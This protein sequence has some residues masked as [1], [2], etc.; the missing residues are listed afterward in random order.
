MDGWIQAGID[1][2]WYG[3]LTCGSRVDSSWYSVANPSAISGPHPRRRNQRRRK[4][5]HSRGDR[6]CT[7]AAGQAS[8]SWAMFPVCLCVFKV[9]RWIGG[10]V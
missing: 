2:V 3:S 1:H 4:A 9:G 6:D 8:T 10:W 7:S 5:R